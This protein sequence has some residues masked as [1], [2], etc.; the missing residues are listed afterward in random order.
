MS[1]FLIIG[2]T[3]LPATGHVVNKHVQTFNHDS[4]DA[5]SLA[6]WYSLQK[7]ILKKLNFPDG[8]V[9]AD[10]IFTLSVVNMEDTNDHYII[11]KR[12]LA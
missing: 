1:K 3:S 10:I 7:D 4:Y 11:V 12:N 2:T 9:G 5:E 6:K 8:T